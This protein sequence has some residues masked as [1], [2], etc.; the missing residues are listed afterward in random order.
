M[1]QKVLS[2]I[3][4]SEKRTPP[5]ILLPMPKKCDSIFYIDSLKLLTNIELTI[6]I[7]LELVCNDFLKKRCSTATSFLRLKRKKRKSNS[8]IDNAN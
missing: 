5:K 7:M 2:Q 3:S 6:K 8:S 4:A 1:R